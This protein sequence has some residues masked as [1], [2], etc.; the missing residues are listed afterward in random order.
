MKQILQRLMAKEILSQEDTKKIMVNITEEKYTNEQIAA[1]LGMMQMRGVSVDELLGFREGLLSTGKS[2][3]L[4][5]YNTIDIVG[6]GG[7]GKN[8]FNISTCSCFVLAGAGYKVAKH[9][10]VAATSVS[11]ASNV[12]MAHG[13]KFTDDVNKHKENLEKAGITYLHA[14]LFAYGMK[15][16]GPIR[17]ALQVPTLF[18]LLGPLVNPSK[19]QNQVIGTAN[20]TQLRLYTNVF[21]KMGINYTIVTSTD[22]YDEISLTSSFKVA[23]ATEEKIYSVAETGLPAVLPDEI[24]GGKDQ[25]LED[26]KKVFDDVLNNEGKRGP[27][28]VVLINSAFAIHTLCPNKSIEEC[29]AEAKESI[30]SGKAMQALKTYVTLNS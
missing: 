8:T 28:N 15:F 1:M 21:Q 29:I 23:T 25:T 5:E 10:N 4:S 30:E 24:C 2:V 19:P 17:K 9:G 22:G 13:V 18:N 3:D 7:D 16:V 27:K 14:P 6:T 26:A 12:L 11:G 20:L